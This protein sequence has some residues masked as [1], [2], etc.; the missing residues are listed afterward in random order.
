MRAGLAASAGLILLLTGCTP[1]NTVPS[2]TVEPARVGLNNYEVDDAAL[3]SGEIEG[4][5]ILVKQLDSSGTLV[6][7]SADFRALAHP[8]TLTLDGD[9]ASSSVCGA[10]DSTV[11]G[12]YG[13]I[14]F[15][16][17]TECGR[18]ANGRSVLE[19]PEFVDPLAEKFTLVLGAVDAARGDGRILELSGSAGVL[20]FE[21]SGRVSVD[22]LVG[23]TWFLQSMD[24][25]NTS[26]LFGEDSELT[27]DLDGTV[28]GSTECRDF[29][30]IWS[31]VDE[32]VTISNAAP[33]DTVCPFS[34]DL[35]G[36][37]D[38][39]DARMLAA[40]QD[41]TVFDLNGGM[42]TVVDIENGFT[43]RYG[44]E[45]VGGDGI[46]WEVSDSGVDGG[47]FGEP[48]DAPPVGEW[49][50]YGGAD[51]LGFVRDESSESEFDGTV[52]MFSET[53]F[54]TGDGCG[55]I[56]GSFQ[57]LPSSVGRMFTVTARGSCVLDRDAGPEFEF[58][59][60]AERA[61]TALESTTELRASDEYFYA[62]HGDYYLRF[63]PVE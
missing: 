6:E 61:Q 17:T 55:E 12:G 3:L 48:I 43:L 25:G 28:S 21:R 59:G 35:L 47:K 33:D 63:V 8:V 34:A 52:Y 5:W 41:G 54:S 11:K 44:Q 45:D 24:R 26:V 42:L 7:P 32:V 30:A 15:T 1:A 29:A 22:A 40:L 27:F 53:G 10:N 23:Q 9:T 4:S 50:L 16:A 37:T 36:N 39:N 20:T 46:S 56:S 62:I 19:P 13:P 49:M 14:D 60:Y 57:S 58:D 18:A 38:L 2:P 51:Y 31:L